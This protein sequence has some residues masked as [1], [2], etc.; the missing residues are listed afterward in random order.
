MAN[1]AN[2]SSRSQVLTLNIPPDRVEK[3]ALAWKSND[4]LCPSHFLS[5]LPA[6]VTNVSDV[7]TLSLNLGMTGI[8]LCL[9]EME[10]LSPAT[11]GHVDFCLFARIC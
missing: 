10:S 3:C 2:M 6:P 8:I 5:I 7:L 4:N 1:L 11:L 9:S